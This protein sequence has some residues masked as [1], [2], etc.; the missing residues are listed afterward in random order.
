MEYQG[1]RIF[2]HVGY[3]DFYTM[4]VSQH[5]RNETIATMHRYD[6][7]GGR[8]EMELFAL[9]MHRLLTLPMRIF[10]YVAITLSERGAAGD[11]NRSAKK[12]GGER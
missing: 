3:I 12:T 10:L 11:E 8:G 6:V 1:V 9:V 4:S 2:S 5:I 7:F